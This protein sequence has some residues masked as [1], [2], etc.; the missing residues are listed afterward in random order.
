MNRFGIMCQDTVFGDIIC[1]GN[2]GALFVAIAA[3]EGNI[4]F[5]CL[6]FFVTAGQDIVGSVAARAMWGEP[7]SLLRQLAMQA[8][9]IYLAYIIMAYSAIDRLHILAVRE[10][11]PGKVLM[12]IHAFEVSMD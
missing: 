5:K 12:A 11:R 1:L 3:H 8:F 9:M 4:K 6:G 7:G 2:L 10:L